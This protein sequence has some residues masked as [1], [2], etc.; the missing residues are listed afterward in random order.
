MRTQDAESAASIQA[1]S[2]CARRFADLR[3]KL[4]K[5]FS[6]IA[7]RLIAIVLI[8]GVLAFGSL[9]GLT[10]WRFVSALQQQAD[11][12]EQLIKRQLA[13]R[14]NAEAQLAKARLEVLGE[15]ASV[16]LRQIAQRTDVMK[17]VGS[18]ND[19]SIRE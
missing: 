16:R 9:G 19:V 17:A 4:V 11:A 13:S 15:E 8:T 3:S 10:A 18:G 12:S 1:T 5:R 6:S 7:A 2:R 14:L